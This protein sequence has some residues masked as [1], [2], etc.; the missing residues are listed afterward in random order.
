M[1]FRGRPEI[2]Q[3]VGI[4]INKIVFGCNSGKKLT[5][6]KKKVAT[7]SLKITAH[8]ILK[9]GGVFRMS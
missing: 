4:P 6:F 7:L 8:L 2:K 1:I 5:F 3:E 9:V